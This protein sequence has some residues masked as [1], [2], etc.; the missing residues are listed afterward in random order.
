MTLFIEGVNLKFKEKY[1]KKIKADKKGL[2]TFANAFF[3]VGY[4]VDNWLLIKDNGNEYGGKGLNP[5]ADL[6]YILREC[7]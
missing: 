6:F 1:T 4:T 5:M 3:D 2:I 7:V